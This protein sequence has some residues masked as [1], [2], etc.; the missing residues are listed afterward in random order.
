MVFDLF[1]S[2]Q[3]I[4]TEHL[5]QQSVVPDAGDA[6]S[7][8]QSPSSWNSIVLEDTDHKVIKLIS[9][10]DEHCE[11]KKQGYEIVRDQGTVGGLCTWRGR[12]ELRERGL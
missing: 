12:E 11:E 10:S 1:F 7:T 4:F 3:Q 6:Q 8:T 9:D 2:L 5:L